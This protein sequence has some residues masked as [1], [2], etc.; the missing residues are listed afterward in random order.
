MS[1]F[2]LAIVCSHPIQYYAPWFRELATHTEL[3]IRVFYLWDFGVG[4]RRDQG[5][6]RKLTWD[7]PLLDG[8][9][10]E[11]VPNLSL[12]PG[13]HHFFGL[14]NPT[15]SGK[16]RT[17]A[18][19][20]VLLFGYR[21]FT[22]TWFLLA[23]HR[24]WP[25]LFRGDSH[26]LPGTGNDSPMASRI[27][28]RIFNRFAGFLAV[29]T[30]N[31]DYF[32]NYGVPENRIFRCPHAIDN[33]RFSAG[34]AGVDREKWRADHG[35]G[36]DQLAVLFPGKLIEKKRPFDLV[37]A[38]RLVGDERICPVFAGTGQLE[39]RLR[40]A[41]P[42]RAVFLGWQNQSAMPAIYAAV[43]LVVLPS[44]GR[45]ETWG[46]ATNEAM[47]AG[48]PCVT[49]DHVGCAQDLIREGQTGWTFPAGDTEALA[50]VLAR[51]ANKREE[52]PVM[53]ERARRLV[54]EEFSY[55]NCSEALFRAVAQ[56]CEKK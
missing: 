3:A 15:L 4:D 8:Y 49:S 6:G 32:R 56:I 30:A 23:N 35:I 5:F 9:E 41:A 52:L 21:P 53:G 43:D 50:A 7:L 38:I 1:R 19:D 44:R 47:A 24:R 31:R 18:P 54:T 25:L 11:F 28:P 55:A 45:H 17:F 42:D 51:A 14:V 40:Q 16:V 12:R 36:P 34:A 33:A 27:L 2:R 29:G 39:A 13:T 37:E 10:S 46:L 48:T 20:A 22:L 26:R